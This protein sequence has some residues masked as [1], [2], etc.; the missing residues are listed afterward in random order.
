[1]RQANGWGFRRITQGPD[2]NSYYHERFL[3]G[4]PHLC[5]TMKRPGVA[6]KKV[7]DPDLEPD[8]S[9]ISE[10]YPVPKNADEESMFLQKTLESGPNSRMPIITGHFLSNNSHQ[11]QG[12]S[13]VN[14]VSSSEGTAN[15]KSSSVAKDRPRSES[16]SMSSVPQHQERTTVTPETHL[17]ESTQQE[18][19]FQ[20]PIPP[21]EGQHDHS[22]AAGFAAAAAHYQQHFYHIMQKMAASG[23]QMLPMQMQMQVGGAGAQQN[24]SEENSSMARSA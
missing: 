2:R 22:Y 5:K 24:N 21:V 19:M 16:Y 13:D 14:S 9:K 11:Q 8:F 23:G 7:V 18:M 12:N 10:M 4:L 6:E 20:V 3:R 17:K 1:V 15:T